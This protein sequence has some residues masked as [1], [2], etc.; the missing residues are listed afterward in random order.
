[1]CT[2]FGTL[3]ALVVGLMAG[4]PDALKQGV[5]GTEDDQDRGAADVAE[6]DVNEN[7]CVIRIAASGHTPYTLGG[8]QEA[9]KRR[10][11]TVSIAC[12]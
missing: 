2:T 10:A 7:D 5:E 8:L 4:D 6:L 3:P 9:K 1:M 12:N 11:L